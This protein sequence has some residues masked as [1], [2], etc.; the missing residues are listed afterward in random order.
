MALNKLN[1]VFLT[2]LPV[3]IGMAG[4][5]RILSLARGVQENHADATILILNPTEP[6]PHVQNTDTTG[7]YKGVKYKYLTKTTVIPDGKLKKMYHFLYGLHKLLP[8][9][10]K[11]HNKNRIDGIVMMHT[12]S[13]VPILVFFFTRLYGIPLLQ[14]RNEFPFLSKRGLFKKI[15]YFIYIHFTIKL[16]DGFLLITNNLVEYFKAFVPRKT[17]LWHLPMTVEYDRFQK[18]EKHS[19]EKYIAYCGYL[20]GDKDGVPILI[21]AF[22]K[23]TNEFPEIKLVLVGDVSNR[24]EKNKLDIL[25]ND[26]NIV[27]KVTFTGR[28]KQSEVTQILCDAKILALARPDNVQS[29]GGFPTKLGEYLATGNPVVVTKV[30]EIPNYLSDGVN[31]FLS[32]PNSADDFA[33]KLK[34]VLNNQEEAKKIGLEG[35]KLVESTFSYLVQGSR[36][37]KSL[38]E[39]KRN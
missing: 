13:I 28:V 14:E 36:I 29:K 24:K 33:E 2:N 16:F 31:A 20:W 1:I 19:K 4:T 34:Q 10:K 5:N 12:L 22:A 35:R 25:L 15:D 7:I 21:K 23:I 3:P 26:L 8:Q 39:F 6:P 32:A 17:K 9:L 37:I 30:G 18:I 27:D 38:K 11:M